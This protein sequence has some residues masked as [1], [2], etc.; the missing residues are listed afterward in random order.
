[1]P[2]WPLCYGGVLPPLD[3][4]A[5]IETTHR[6]FAITTTPLIVAAA[7][8][9]WRNHR[10]VRWLSRTLFA[11]VALTLAVVVFGAFAVLTGLPRPV[12]AID[13][14]CALLVLA[15]VLTARGVAQARSDDPDLPDRL[16]LRD[17]LARLTLA[18]LAAV[19]LLLVSGV[20]VA[21]VGSIAR[22]LGWP[23]YG[24]VAGAAEV[25]AVL[26]PLRRA[27]GVVAA[28][29]IAAVVVEAWRGPR[30]GAASSAIR[31]TATA[32]ALVLLAEA[33]TGALVVAQGFSLALGS[34]HVAAAVG[35]W[36]L[37]GA[38]LVETATARGD[39]PAA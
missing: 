29:L 23:L 21:D 3:M 33:A 7:V 1:V 14:G 12:A 16:S 19:Y 31:R 13:V 6:L 28:G 36:A 24:A 11:A 32:L 20:L 35:V 22:C 27:L 37:L 34:F 18:S 5:I 2:D 38:L 15:L 17:A 10:G 25:G 39:A 4:G 30:A 8:V 9:A 26:P